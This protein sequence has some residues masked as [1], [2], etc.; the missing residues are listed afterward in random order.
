MNKRGFTLVEI[1]IV[2][3]IIA[4]LTAIA[5]PAF[6]QY[7]KDSRR[8]LCINNM[9]LIDHAKEVL[10]IK[11][12]WPIGYDV[13]TPAGWW[14]ELRGY[15]DAQLAT[16]ENLYCPEDGV[17]RNHYNYNPIGTRPTCPVVASFPE[18]LYRQ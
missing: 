2:V 1:M 15:I 6:L 3:A 14:S 7:R 11:K 4:L 12:D 10:A 17:T 8:S 13:G 16:N 18:H 5:I 9:R